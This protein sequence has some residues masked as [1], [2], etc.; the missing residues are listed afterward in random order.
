MYKEALAIDKKALGDDHPAV[1]TDLNNLAGCLRAMVCFAFYIT[2]HFCFLNFYKNV[3]TG[4]VR[5]GTSDVQGGSG[6]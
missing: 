6:H 2:F 3:C 1:A 5:G 4:Q